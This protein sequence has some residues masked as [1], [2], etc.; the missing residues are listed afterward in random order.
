MRILI[1]VDESPHASEALRWAAR[2]GWPAGSEVL[3]FSAVRSDLFVTGSLY[4]PA[5]QEIELLVRAETE[6]AEKL[7]AEALPALAAA[8]LKATAKVGHGDPRISILDE[9]K[10]FGADLLIVG[11]HGRRGLAK[12]VLGSVA[13]HV[14]THAPCSVL[15]AKLPAQG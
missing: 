14:V 13:T 11:S 1:A 7:L 10:A 8:G 3:V 12:L 6:R 9:A 4:P 2:L 5:A 15:V